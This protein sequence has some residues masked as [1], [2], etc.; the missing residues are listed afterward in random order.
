MQFVFANEIVCK[1]TTIIEHN[2]Q[3]D[4]GPP[5]GPVNVQLAV[6]A[7]VR[8][9]RPTGQHL[10]VCDTPSLGVTSISLPL[11]KVYCKCRHSTYQSLHQV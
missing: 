3:S 4:M 8:A 10:I 9:L 7:A 1:M 5:D 2:T 11:H 6:A